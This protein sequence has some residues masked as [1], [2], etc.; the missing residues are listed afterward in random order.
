MIS[1]TLLTAKGTIE[2]IVSLTQQGSLTTSSLA[3]EM[4]V[5]ESTARSRATDLKDVGLVSETAEIRDDR[6]VRV[7]E[8]TSQGEQ[9]ANSLMSIINDYGTDTDSSAEAAEEAE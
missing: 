7:F 6:P 2:A 9:L 4:D 1:Q 5:A 8:T 3:D